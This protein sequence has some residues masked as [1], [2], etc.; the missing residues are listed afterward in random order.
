MC[1]KINST[2]ADDMEVIENKRYDYRKKSQTEPPICEDYDDDSL[3]V[4]RS[5][6]SAFYHNK[7]FSIS[8]LMALKTMNLLTSQSKPT[9]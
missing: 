6:Q 1:E 9:N 5:E 7:I 3:F 4:C 2:V 8:K